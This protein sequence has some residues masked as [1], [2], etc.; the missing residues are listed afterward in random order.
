MWVLDVDVIRLN[1]PTH[2]NPGTDKYICDPVNYTTIYLKAKYTLDFGQ[3]NRDQWCTRVHF[4]L[5]V[6]EDGGQ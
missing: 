4:P 3:Y 1:P 5:V 6:T 2:I